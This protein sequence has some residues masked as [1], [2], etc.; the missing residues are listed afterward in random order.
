MMHALVLSL[1]FAPSADPVAPA[2]RVTLSGTQPLSKHAAALMQQANVMIDLDRAAKDRAVTL[3]IKSMLLWQALEQLAKKAD[4]RLVVSGQG[5]RIMLIGGAN[6]HYRA[7]PFDVNGPFRTAAK[8]TTCKLD[9]ETG[10]RVCEVQIEIVWEPR[11]RAF[12]AEVPAKSVSATDEQNKP[13]RV[14]SDGSSKMP[15]TGF[16]IEW[17]ARIADVPR[18]QKNLA[19]LQG[20][21]KFAGTTQL[22]QFAFD[23]DAAGAGSKQKQSG[24]AATLHRFQKRGRIWTA[25]IQFEYPKGGPEFESF[26]SFLLDN[27]CWLQRGNGTK[28][29]STGFEVGGEQGGVIPVSYHFQENPKKSLTIDDVRGWKVVVRSPGPIIEVPLRFTLKDVPL[30]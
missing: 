26:Q 12:Y 16:A 7:V 28:F 2:T 21:V 20:T 22:L 10:E 30:P 8:R 3:D 27:E 6:A 24:V 1:L 29:R 19:A 14:M 17:S 11:F 15:V 13:L 5:G 4:H 25:T 23:A 18:T 9:L